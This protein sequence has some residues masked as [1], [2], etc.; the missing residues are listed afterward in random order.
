MTIVALL[1]LLLIM[2]VIL[3]VAAIT[4]RA[5]FFVFDIIEMASL[6]PNFLMFTEQWKF[7]FRIVIEF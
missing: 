7:S 1:T 2:A 4:I 5:D 3:A 6:T